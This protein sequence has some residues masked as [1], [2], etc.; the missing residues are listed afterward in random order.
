MKREDTADI[1]RSLE[2]RFDAID[3]TMMERCLA[4][5]MQAAE[6]R[7]RGPLQSTYFGEKESP[8]RLMTSMRWSRF[9]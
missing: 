7:W 4:L 1:M 9:D 8:R 2:G 5:A 3:R 6:P